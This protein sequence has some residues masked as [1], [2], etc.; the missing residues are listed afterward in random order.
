[1]LLNYTKY[2]V[3]IILQDTL[4]TSYF[5]VLKCECF[6]HSKRNM[7]PEKKITSHFIF[8]FN[9]SF[10]PPHNYLQITLGCSLDFGQFITLGGERAA[11][12]QETG[13]NAEI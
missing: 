2:S 7:N 6:V 9:M 8:K 3:K 11:G 10:F 1:M 13:R 4:N 12:M 5:S